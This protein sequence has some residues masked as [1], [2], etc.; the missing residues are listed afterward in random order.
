MDRFCD[1]CAT[2]TTSVFYDARTRIGG[3]AFMCEKCF[4]SGPGIGKL[5]TGLGQKYEAQDG[6]WVKTAG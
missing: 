5:G 2:P 4:T 1:I 6:K 3:W